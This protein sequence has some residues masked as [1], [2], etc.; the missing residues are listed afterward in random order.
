MKFSRSL[1]FLAA[2]ALIAGVAGVAQGQTVVVDNFNTGSVQG[3]E[4]VGSTWVNQTTLTG[5]ELVVGGSAKDDNGWGA[6]GVNLNATGMGYLAVTAS[7]DSGNLASQFSAAFSDDFLATENVTISTSMFTSTLSTVYIPVAWTSG[8]D[9]SAITSWT[10]GGGSAGTDTFR[11][12][13][14]NIAFTASAV[15][16]PSTYALLAGVAMLAFVAVRRRRLSV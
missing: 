9:L 2:F 14:D 10:I 15:P 4:Q 6:T 12:T 8:I 7:V 1:K 3:M 5:T 13:F 11:M 16:E